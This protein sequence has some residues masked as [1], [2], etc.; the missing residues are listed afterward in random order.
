MK[1]IV[2]KTI[3][4]QFLAENAL[5]GAIGNAFK[6]QAI[7]EQW[8][9][10]EISAVLSEAESKDFDHFMLTITTHCLPVNDTDHE[11]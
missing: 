6:Q 9:Q 5:Q 8:S 3:S 7:T 1:R 4:M 10:E 11:H 2:D